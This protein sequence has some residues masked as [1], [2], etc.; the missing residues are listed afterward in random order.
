MPPAPTVDDR[1]PPDTINAEELGVIGYVTIGPD[2][3]AWGALVI[4]AGLSQFTIMLT[5]D[6]LARLATDLPGMMTE[7]ANE[8]RRQR[9]GLVIGNPDI[10]KGRR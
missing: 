5:P 10:L 7:L 2:H 4:S 9:N 8:V 6:A 3:K 1:D